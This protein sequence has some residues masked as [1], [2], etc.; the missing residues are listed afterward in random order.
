MEMLGEQKIRERCERGQVTMKGVKKVA[1]GA[2]LKAK[3][4]GPIRRREDM[5]K[6]DEIPVCDRYGDEIVEREGGTDQLWSSRWA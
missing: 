2:H 6:T 1:V 5:Q 4:L 3:L